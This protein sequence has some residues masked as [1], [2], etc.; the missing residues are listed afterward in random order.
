MITAHVIGSDNN[1]QPRDLDTV[2]EFM[3]RNKANTKWLKKSTRSQD[4]VAENAVV[5]AIHA[6][7]Q[8]CLS[9]D[10]NHFGIARAF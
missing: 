5:I 3:E 2:K 10:S 1:V 6:D 8:T 4:T 9:S 7:M